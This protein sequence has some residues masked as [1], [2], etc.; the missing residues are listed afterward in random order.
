[1]VLFFFSSRRRHT[2]LVSDWSSDVCS[3]DLTSQGQ[4]RDLSGNGNHGTLTG[5]TAV[6]GVFGGARGFD[7]TDD[8]IECGDIMGGNSSVT[9][10]AWVSTRTLDSAR[11]EV[12][13]N[14]QGWGI[15]IEYTNRIAGYVWGQVPELQS[16]DVLS[17]DVWYHI[18]LTYDGT[19]ANLYVNGTLKD[20]RTYAVSLPDGNLFRIG[21]GISGHRWNGSV[22]EVRVFARALNASEIAGLVSG[23]AHAVAISSVQQPSPA[24]S[25]FLVWA[26]N[27]GGTSSLFIQQS[28]MWSVLWSA[29]TVAF[30][31][32]RFPL[33]EPQFAFAI[34]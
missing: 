21:E 26:L 27:L 32:G 16:T 11:H 7:G 30:P 8:H 19:T 17:A 4:V 14:T 31:N 29:A 5:T 34:N 13:Q 12:A 25:T 10:A 3:S 24:V 18:A 1:M 6:V 15:K 22:D 9:V 33:R 20:S 28:I 2:R 23:S